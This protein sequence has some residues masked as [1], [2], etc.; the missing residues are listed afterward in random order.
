MVDVEQDI[1]KLKHFPRLSK[2]TLLKQTMTTQEL[3][4]DSNLIQ[5]ACLQCF[6]TPDFWLADFPLSN[7]HILW[8]VMLL[9]GAS[10]I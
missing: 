8:S 4:E 5:R 6:P 1:F 10:T 3:F 9:K 2:V 7:S